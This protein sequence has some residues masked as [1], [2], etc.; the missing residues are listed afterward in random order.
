[1]RQSLTGGGF[2]VSSCFTERPSTKEGGC[3][4]A[5]RAKVVVQ[6][7]VAPL[8]AFGHARAAQIGSSAHHR[9]EYGPTY[10]GFDASSTDNL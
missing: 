7:Q 8:A 10:I 9:D 4:P 5:N 3:T 6:N 2:E 1:V